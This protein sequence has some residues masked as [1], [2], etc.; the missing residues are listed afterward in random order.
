[1][2]AKLSNETIPEVKRTMADLVRLTHVHKVYGGGLSGVHALHDV[3]LQ[4]GVGEMVVV[5]GPTERLT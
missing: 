1:M 2:D 5:C 3:C 4:V